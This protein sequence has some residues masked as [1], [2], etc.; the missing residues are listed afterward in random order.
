MSYPLSPLPNIFANASLNSREAGRELGRDPPAVVD[1]FGVSNEPGL[2]RGI[3]SSDGGREDLGVR[4][5]KHKERTSHER[6]YSL[7]FE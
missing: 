2:F 5:L 7:L 6:C 3:I 1:L 4:T